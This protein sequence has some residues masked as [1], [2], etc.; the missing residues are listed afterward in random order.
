MPTLPTPVFYR[1]DEL[2]TIAPATINGA[3]RDESLAIASGG[4][5]GVHGALV[6]SVP[7][8]PA[9][10]TLTLTWACTTRADLEALKDFLARR[11]G[12][13]VP[14]WCPTY[15]QDA[16]VVTL[17][18][19]GMRITDS[20][21]VNAFPRLAEERGGFDVWCS[22]APTGSTVRA[23]VIDAESNGD[24][25]ADLTFASLEALGGLTTAQGAAF[26]RM[27]LVRLTDDAIT[28]VYRTGHVAEIAVTV[29]TVP[30]EVT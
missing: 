5:R 9:G 13:A 17:I 20:E 19:G 21:Y 6:P 30:R 27:E 8:S 4:A 12:R 2:L 15:R 26:S 29:I 22:T 7:D 10:E 1:N 24:G 3:T 23:R 18:A 14:F 25:T 28:T 11:R 16:T